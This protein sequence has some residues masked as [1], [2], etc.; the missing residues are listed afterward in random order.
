MRARYPDHDGFVEREGIKIF[1][2]VFGEGEPTV[3]LL[4]SWSIFHSHCWKAQV[5]YLARH[6]RVITFDGRGNGRSDR[7]QR[8]EDYADALFV[9]DALAVLDATATEQAVVVGLS[10]GADWAL[11]LAADHPERVSRIVV[12]G[13]AIALGPPPP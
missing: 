11:Q 12:T 6:A 5:P 2:E 10:R 13:P 4:P 3:L 9:A 7:P 1:Y 8:P